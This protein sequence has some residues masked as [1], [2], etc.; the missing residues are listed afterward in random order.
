MQILAPVL[1]LPFTLAEFEA[2]R[3]RTVGKV[4]GQELE[5]LRGLQ[6]L[7]DA[8]DSCV[9]RFCRLLQGRIVDYG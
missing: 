9:W 5:G 2:I 1:F 7:S 6:D 4:R 3:S 8:T